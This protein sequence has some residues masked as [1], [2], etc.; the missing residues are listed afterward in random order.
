M[1]SGD[2]DSVAVREREAG[3]RE[4]LAVHGISPRIIPAG[5]QIDD[6][7]RAA[8]ALLAGRDA[9]TGIFCIRDRVAAGALHAAVAAGFDVPGD[10][11][12]VGFDDEDF[13]AETLTPPLTTIALPHEE[14]GG[15]AMA[16]LLARLGAEHSDAPL[17]GGIDV[18]ECP[19]VERESVGR[20][21]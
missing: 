18:V 6:G 9:P 20:P 10:F 3:F 4:E 5:W 17:G 14:M 2:D 13:F 16:H 19:L 12:I 1:L 11:S 8:T 15:R 21:R 7:Y